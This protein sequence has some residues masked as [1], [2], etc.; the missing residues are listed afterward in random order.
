MFDEARGT[1]IKTRRMDI[2]EGEPHGV[3]EVENNGG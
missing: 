1:M 3:Q 2:P